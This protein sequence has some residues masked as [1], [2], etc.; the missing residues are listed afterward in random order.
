MKRTS[1][2]VDTGGGVPRGHIPVAVEPA[3]GKPTQN[4]VAKLAHQFWD[5][6]GQQ[7]ASEESNW[8]EAERQLRAIGPR[9]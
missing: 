4:D 5:E 9:K 8:F 6:R 3:V 2:T 1:E 7:S